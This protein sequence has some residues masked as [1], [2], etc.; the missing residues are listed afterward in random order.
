MILNIDSPN[1][2]IRRDID[3]HI[4]KINFRLAPFTLEFDIENSF[5]LAVHFTEIVAHTFGLG[6]QIE[7]LRN[8]PNTDLK[9][10]KLEL[11]FYQDHSSLQLGKISF[12]QTYFGIPLWHTNF[13]LRFDPKK[14]AIIAAESHV[15]YDK[16][17]FKTPKLSAISNYQNL[18]SQDLAALL[19]FGKG[20]EFVVQKSEQL[21]YY[22]YSRKERLGAP[23]RE[24]TLQAMLEVAKKL[25]PVPLP[26]EQYYLSRE[27]LFSYYVEH[28]GIINWR[29]FIEVETGAILHL[30]PF[31]SSL[32]G[33]VFENDPSTEGSSVNVEDNDTVLNP[34][35]K[36][37]TL[38]RLEAPVEGV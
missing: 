14:L 27:V 21:Y 12:I 33:L 36:P 31:T 3:G 23:L 29:C 28:V 26:N 30:F 25:L 22:K 9:E 35:R 37:I 15:T 17:T 11:R 34:V 7:N 16:I 20:E 19:N 6:E 4:R 18:S 5:D 2:A 32:S 8:L 38:E 24:T 1:L 10:N 13:H